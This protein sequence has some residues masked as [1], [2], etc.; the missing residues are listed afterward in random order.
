MD[1]QICVS[2]LASILEAV[3]DVRFELV[4][5]TVN[6]GHD[7]RMGFH[8]RETA[9]ICG[10]GKRALSTARDASSQGSAALS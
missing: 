6:K 7:H 9:A 8:W 1:L 3:P 5:S 10:G 2:L 4:N